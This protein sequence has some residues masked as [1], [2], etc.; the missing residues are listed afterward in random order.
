LEVA[1]VRLTMGDEKETSNA[2]GI[3]YNNVS[4]EA[5]KM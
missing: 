5:E 3:V 2:E 4:V 1:G